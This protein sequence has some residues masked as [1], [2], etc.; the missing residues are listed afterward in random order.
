MLPQET[1]QRP[2][3]DS[4][5][6]TLT[7]APHFQSMME[8]PNASMEMNETKP[9]LGKGEVDILECEFKK[10]PKPPTRTKRQFAEDM[11]VDLSRINVRQSVP[12]LKVISRLII[13]RLGSKTVEQSVSRRRS[14]RL[15]R[16]GKLKM[17]WGNIQNHHR[18]VL[19][20][21]IRPSMNQPRHSACLVDLHPQSLFTT[22]SILTL[23]LRAWSPCTGLWQPLKLQVR[24]VVRA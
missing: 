14:R 6:H 16:L 4:I 11:G 7:V 24:I 23:R 15:M 1:S 19:I 21:Q 8:Q 5:P 2:G 9:R 22:L 18:L 13:H 17:L 12:N 10:N 3:T 20:T